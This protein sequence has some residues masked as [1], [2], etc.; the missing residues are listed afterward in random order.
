MVKTL[1]RLTFEVYADLALAT[2]VGPLINL[3][4]QL[5]LELKYT[6]INID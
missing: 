6:L 3:Q 5:Q 2:T 1:E 4:L